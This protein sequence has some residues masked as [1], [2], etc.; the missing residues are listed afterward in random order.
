MTLQKNPCPWV[1]KFTI[2]V[3]HSLVSITIYLVCL[4]YA[5][6]LRGRFLK[7]HCVFQYVTY[8]VMP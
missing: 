8:M 5:Q 2:L 1:M 7:K 3:G 4:I 6:K